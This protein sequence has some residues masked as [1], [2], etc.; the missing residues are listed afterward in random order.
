MGIPECR[1]VLGAKL[2]LPRAGRGHRAVGVVGLGP[3]LGLLHRP[4]AAAVSAGP[5]APPR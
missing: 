4:M 2:G 5:A 1:A 3:E